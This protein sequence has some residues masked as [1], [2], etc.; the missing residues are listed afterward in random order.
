MNTE[1]QPAAVPARATWILWGLV[2]VY[3]I[4]PLDAV[5][6]PVDD[7]VLL[8]AAYAYRNELAAHIERFLRDKIGGGQWNS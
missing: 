5:P 1:Q 7:W 3:Y 4:S 8:G 2:A 6:G